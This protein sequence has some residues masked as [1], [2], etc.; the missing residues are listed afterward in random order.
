MMAAARAL[1]ARQQELAAVAAQKTSAVWQTLAAR[2]QLPAGPVGQAAQAPLL[3]LRGLPH[4][5]QAEPPA[6][7]LTWAA[8]V[9]RQVMRQGGCPA[10]AAQPA[11]GELSRVPVSSGRSRLAAAWPA[12]APDKES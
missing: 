9:V 7:L 2:A 12:A 4:Q 6:A 10:L 1:A 3:E 11:A 5:A 8:R